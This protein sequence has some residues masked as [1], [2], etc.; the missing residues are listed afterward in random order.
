MVIPATYGQDGSGL[1]DEDKARCRCNS[2][3]HDFYI[4]SESEYK[5]L[6]KC[7][8]GLERNLQNFSC[9]PQCQE[10]HYRKSDGICYYCDT[11]SNDIIGDQ[12][13]PKCQFGQERLGEECVKQ[14]PMGK[15]RNDEGKCEKPDQCKPNEERHD[16]GVCRKRCPPGQQADDKGKCIQG[17]PFGQERVKGKCLTICR[18]GLER[19]H[20]NC[21]P[22]CSDGYKRNDQ[23][24]CEYCGANEPAVQIQRVQ[25]PIDCRNPTQFQLDNHICREGYDLPLK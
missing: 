17:C 13:L 16:D 15:V 19:V 9:I 1:C 2:E 7:L 14:C 4:M 11:R 18:D 3:T 10:N 5:C 24:I 12:C 23:G 25:E 20:G 22:A 21:V 8:P 6:P